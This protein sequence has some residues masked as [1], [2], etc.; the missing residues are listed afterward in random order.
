LCFSLL[1]VQSTQKIKSKSRRQL[2]DGA[3]L[4]ESSET[5]EEDDAWML[6]SGRFPQGC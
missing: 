5:L 6:C 3:L 1:K 4:G 2:I